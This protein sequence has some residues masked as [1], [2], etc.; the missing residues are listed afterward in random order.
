MT[1]ATLIK[2]LSLEE[3][4]VADRDREIT[5]GYAG[6]L[7]SWV[8]GRAKEGDAWVTIMTN[9]NVLAVASLA[10]VACV[11]LAENVPVEPDI[12][13]AAAAKEITLLRSHLAT[14]DICVKIGNLLNG[15][16][17]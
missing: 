16:S 2:Q 6:D 12:V 11:V 5:G 1:V 9:I 13:Q 3:I 8:M 10:D 7:L 17:A 4:T 14:Y 15:E